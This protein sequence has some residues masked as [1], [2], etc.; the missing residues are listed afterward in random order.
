MLQESRQLTEDIC[1]AIRGHGDQPDVTASVRTM[2]PV[3]QMNLR[4]QRTE[5]TRILAAY[6]SGAHTGKRFWNCV[7][8]ENSIRIV[9]S[10]FVERKGRGAMR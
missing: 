5:R 7:D 8:L 9:N 4:A 3:N 10:R 1:I 2:H 6:S